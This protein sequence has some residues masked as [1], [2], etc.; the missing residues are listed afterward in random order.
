[1]EFHREDLDN[2]FRDYINS[3]QDEDFL[4]KLYLDKY[5]DH[6]VNVGEFK[7]ILRFR[8]VHSAVLKIFLNNLPRDFLDHL[9]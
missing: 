6:P 2:K 5:E 8:F 9:D 7:K 1:M 4:V 3:H